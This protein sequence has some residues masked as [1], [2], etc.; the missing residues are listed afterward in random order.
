MSRIIQV[1]FRKRGPA[2]ELPAL[3]EVVP[4]AKLLARR[5]VS[6]SAK[7]EAYELYVKASAIDEDPA[8]YDAAESLY[9]RALALDPT[10]AIA[11]TNIGNICYKR[12]N[13]DLAVD[14]YRHALQIDSKQVEALYNLG[15]IRMSNDDFRGA[16]TLLQ[17]AVDIDPRFADAQYNLASTLTELGR[18]ADALPHWKAYIDLEPTGPWADSARQHIDQLR[19]HELKVREK[20]SRRQRPKKIA[21]HFLPGISDWLK[22]PR[23]T[24]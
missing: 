3:A 24:K 7:S 11:L 6:Q 15:Y 23:R 14:H 9:K 4:F 5:P 10:M 22:D 2:R 13:E 21:D 16:L 12:G 19:R 20:K 17:S 8:T 18:H 1:D